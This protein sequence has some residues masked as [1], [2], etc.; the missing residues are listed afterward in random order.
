MGMDKVAKKDAMT[1]YYRN[2]G[3][4]RDSYIGCDN[5]GLSHAGD[6][7][8]KQILPSPQL[9]VGNSQHKPREYCPSP[10]LGMKY[11]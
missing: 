5:G 9:Y 1:V 6:P 3:A 4:G 10:S 8:S 2:D 11:P 7:V